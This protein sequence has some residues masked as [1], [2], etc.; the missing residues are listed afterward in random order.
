LNGQPIHID[1]KSTQVAGKRDGAPRQLATKVTETSEGPPPTLNGQP[2]HIDSKSTQVAGKRDGA[3]RQLATKVTETSEGP[4]PTLNGQPIHIDSKSTQV[5]GKRDGAPRQLATKVTETSEG[6]P[7]TL[8]GQ[9]I[10]IDSKSTQVAGKRDGAP[11]QLATKVTETSEGPPPTLNGQPI[12]ID[13]KSTQ[14]AGKRDAQSTSYKPTCQESIYEA[15]LSDGPTKTISYEGNHPKPGCKKLHGS[16][17]KIDA[18]IDSSTK[19]LDEERKSTK[20][21][22]Q[23]SANVKVDMKASDSGIKVSDT[24]DDRSAPTAVQATG[25]QNVPCNLSPCNMPALHLSVV[26]D[27]KPCDPVVTSNVDIKCMGDGRTPVVKE[28]YARKKSDVNHLVV[29]HDI[30]AD[31][32]Q[33]IEKPSTADAEEVL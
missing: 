16:P 11:R 24:P 5:A 17:K 30:N 33:S 29:V 22:E 27:R 15:Q 2:I 13:S 32:R 23:L 28:E 1:S 19:K 25:R 14:V 21:D 18:T 4:P 31:R 10:H 7:P 20:K 6:P 8:N 12:H 26:N 3:P 9:P